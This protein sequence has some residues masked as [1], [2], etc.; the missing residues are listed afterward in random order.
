VAII[1]IIIIIYNKSHLFSAWI[2][3]GMPNLPLQKC[4]QRTNI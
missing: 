4:Y 1:I 2:L 3:E